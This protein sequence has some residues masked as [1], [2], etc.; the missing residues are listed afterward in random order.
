MRKLLALSK[1][2]ATSGIRSL[3]HPYSVQIVTA[4]GVVKYTDYTRVGAGKLIDCFID[5]D[6]LM[7]LNEAAKY[8]KF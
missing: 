1:R 4:I 3:Q 6:I 2:E 7:P 8:D 5:L